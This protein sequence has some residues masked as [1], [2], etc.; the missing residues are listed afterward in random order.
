MNKAQKFF[1]AAVLLLALSLA[2]VFSQRSS[3]QTNSDTTHGFDRA[4]MDPKAAACTDFYQY[5]NG[6]WL[7]ANPIPAAYPSWGVGNI[8]NEKTRDLL[9]D[10]LEAAAKNTS[11]P[12]GSNEQKVGDYYATCIDET[13]IEADGLKPL[14]GELDLVA[15]M[16]DQGALQKEIAHLHSVGINAAFSSGSTQDFKNSSEVIAGIF[17]GGLGLPDRDYYTKTDERSKGL[18]DEYVKHVAKMFELMGDDGTKAAAEAQ[19]VMTLET[20]LAEGSKTRV[21]L[22]DPE[23]NY[24]RMAMAQ[25]HDVA[26][27]FDWPV[28]FQRTGLSQ[29]TDV[30]IGQPEFFKALDQ[31]LTATPIADWQTYL[32]WN[33]INGTASALSSKFVDEDFHFKGT[34]LQGAKENLPRWKRCVAATDR[35]LGEALGQVYV[36]K[37]FPP[38][39]NGGR[40][41]AQQLMARRL[42]SAGVELV[43]L[44]GYDRILADPFWDILGDVPVINI[45][46]SLLPAFGG[47]NRLKVHEAVLAAGVGEMLFLEILPGEGVHHAD[48]VEPLLYHFDEVALPPAHFAAGVLHRRQLSG[49]GPPPRGHLRQHHAQ[50][51]TRRDA[52][53]TGEPQRLGCRVHEGHT[54]VPGV[55][56]RGTRA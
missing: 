5:A 33:L 15:K 2:A 50:R 26:P 51:D 24:H 36:Q 28:Y 19:T 45:H 8:L 32:R 44:A 34:I 38:A 52:C 31:Q 54:H 56:A 18:R 40:D 10:I 43:V 21:E 3:A 25:V 7:A 22:R 16:S 11:A 14:Q 39:A 48:R 47:L 13:K 30:N 35:A 20:K 9:H 17:Q 4:N 55:R 49:P 42:V 46:P 41:A 12:K 29:R 1:I 23:K 6:G 37:A 53:A 27:T